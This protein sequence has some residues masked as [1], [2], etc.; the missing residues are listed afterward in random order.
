MRIANLID[1]SV[2]EAVMRSEVNARRGTVEVG[3]IKE[4]KPDNEPKK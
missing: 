1:L 3:P 2:G 4:V